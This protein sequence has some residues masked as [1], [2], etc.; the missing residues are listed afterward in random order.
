MFLG[1]E[2][3]SNSSAQAH[4]NKTVARQVNIVLVL[5]LMRSNLSDLKQGNN[6]YLYYLE[7]LCN[8]WLRAV[9]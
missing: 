4:N 8:L 2:S 7:G 1:D 3:D 9:T 5:L 6:L